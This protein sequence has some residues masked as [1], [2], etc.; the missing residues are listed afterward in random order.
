MGLVSQDGVEDFALCDADGEVCE[1]VKIIM[2]ISPNNDYNSERRIAKHSPMLQ[3][4]LK[5]TKFV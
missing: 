1:N 2:S 5:A 3:D 4:S